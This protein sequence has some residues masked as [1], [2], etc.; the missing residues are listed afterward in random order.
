M[1]RHL[2]EL[3]SALREHA[4]P[5]GVLGP[6]NVLKQQ[7]YQAAVELEYQVITVRPCKGVPSV[8]DNRGRSRKLT[9]R[10]RLAL[11]LLRGKTEIRP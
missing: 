2:T 9:R 10:E 5:M 7:L 6:Q 4:H 3:A 8:H 11:W 1:S